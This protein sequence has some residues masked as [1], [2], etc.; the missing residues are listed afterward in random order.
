[1]RLNGWITPST[2]EGHLFPFD[3]LTLTTLAALSHFDSRDMT[4]LL[5][6]SSVGLE[7]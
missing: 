1:M 4:N 5:K 2:P 3:L 6:T 7:N